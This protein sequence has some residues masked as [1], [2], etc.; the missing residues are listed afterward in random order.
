[1]AFKRSPERSARPP[2]IITTPSGLVRMTT[3]LPAPVICAIESVIGVIAIGSAL[4]RAKSGALAKDAR[5]IP[6]AP[7]RAVLRKSLRPVRDTL[8]GLVSTGSK[9]AFVV[10][11][12]RRSMLRCIGV[13]HSETH[14]L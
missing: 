1:M 4:E 9:A 7:P 8:I 5:L 10:F 6:A 11:S 14:D 3:L 2:S 12:T 13:H